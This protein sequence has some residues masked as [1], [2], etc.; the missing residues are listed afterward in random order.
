MYHQIV[1]KNTPTANISTYHTGIGMY[2]SGSKMALIEKEVIAKSGAFAKQRLCKT[3]MFCS[4]E[5]KNKR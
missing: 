1:T 3:I 5:K 4:D 2:Q